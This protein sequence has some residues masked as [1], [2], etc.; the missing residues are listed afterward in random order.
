MILFLTQRI[1]NPGSVIPDRTLRSGRRRQCITAAPEQR[2]S[3]RVLR[4]L[5]GC[6]QPLRF[7][8]EN[9]SILLRPPWEQINRRTRCPVAVTKRRAQIL[10]LRSG[11]R[12]A[13][14]FN[15]RC[16]GA[17]PSG[18]APSSRF[19]GRGPRSPLPRGP[20]FG[21][22]RSSS[23]WVAVH[24]VR[25]CSGWE[26]TLGRSAAGSGGLPEGRGAAGSPG[27]VSQA[28]KQAGKSVLLSNLLRHARGQWNGQRLCQE[29]QH[30]YYCYYYLKSIPDAHGTLRTT[31]IDGPRPLKLK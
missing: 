26:P 4:W 7:Y 24:G 21:S 25:A 30:Y 15:H 3:R 23:R 27:N 22:T 10:Q 29:L 19:G 2:R 28:C 6:R 31:I 1:C 14:A 20:V 16:F 5:R 11:K 9:H 13:T 18:L 17:S 8:R 12:E